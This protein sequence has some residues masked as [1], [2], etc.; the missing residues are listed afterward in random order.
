MEINFVLFGASTHT[1]LAP[2]NLKILPWMER[3]SQNKMPMP[4]NI[5][6]W[7]ANQSVCQALKKKCNY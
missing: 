3:D 7:E 1:N 6:G 4:C 5:I 2:K